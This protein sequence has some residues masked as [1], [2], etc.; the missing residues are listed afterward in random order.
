MICRS[1]IRLGYGTDFVA[2]HQNYESGYEYEAWMNSGMKP[3]EALRAAT[4][5]NAGIL[6]LEDCIGTVE[7][8]KYADISAWKRDLMKD[9][10]AL[11][12]CA[13]VMKE[14]EIYETESCLGEGGGRSHPF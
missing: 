4:S 5:T 9:P 6:G 11:L 8:G 14:G 12:D 10:K 7:V 13:F 2:V 3:F 1:K